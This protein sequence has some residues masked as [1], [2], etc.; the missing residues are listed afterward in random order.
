MNTLDSIK[1]T[2]WLRTYQIA[3][4]VIDNA[5]IRSRVKSNIR[6]GI[7]LELMDST[8]ASIISPYVRNQ[9]RY[10]VTNSQVWSKL[11]DDLNDYQ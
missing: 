2:M 11:E 5:A 7:N 6:V 10:V 4:Q 1:T 9:L 8:L 3:R